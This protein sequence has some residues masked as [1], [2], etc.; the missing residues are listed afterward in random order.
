MG[1]GDGSHEKWALGY[2]D[3]APFFQQAL[4]LGITFWDTCTVMVL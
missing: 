4:E 1:F 2:E 3:A